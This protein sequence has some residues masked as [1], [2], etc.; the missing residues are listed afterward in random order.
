MNSW[1]IL[2]QPIEKIKN[3]YRYLMTIRGTGMKTM[4]EA[5]RI[6]ALHRPVPKGVEVA[7]DVDAQNL[8]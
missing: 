2:F 4:R 1:S 3:K 8:M 7:V 5:V 6:L